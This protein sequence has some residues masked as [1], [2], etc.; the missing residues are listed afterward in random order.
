MTLGLSCA[1]CLLCKYTQLT[2]QLQ[3]KCIYSWCLFLF[4]F[5]FSSPFPFGLHKSL[6][7]CINDKG[8]NEREPLHVVVDCTGVRDCS[9]AS[10]F[11]TYSETGFMAW[12]PAALH[13]LSLSLSLSE[14]KH[15]STNTVL[16]PKCQL[17]SPRAFPADL[18]I[19]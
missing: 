12:L 5:L 15:M 4:L 6:A 17:W 8:D 3:G 16:F 10:H 14:L 7:S 11:L 1:L 2:L 9:L 18:E 19:T 13:P